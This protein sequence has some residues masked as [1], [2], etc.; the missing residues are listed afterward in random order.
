[1]AYQTDGRVWPLARC[2]LNVAGPG[3][4]TAWKP[5]AVA[6]MSAWNGAGASFTFSS[7]PTATDHLAAYDLGR[8]NGWLAMT[9]TQPTSAG[10][11]LTSGQI[12]VNLY[13]E[14]NPS[15]PTVAP[16]SPKGA[17]DLESVLIHEFGHLLHLADEITARDVM[18]P[19][20]NPGVIRRTL[21]TDDI[22]GIQYLYPML[23]GLEVAELARESVAVVL[24]KVLACGYAVVSLRPFPEETAPEIVFSV[25]RVQVD[26][27]IRGSAGKMKE[28]DVLTLGGQTPKLSLHVQSE[29]A[30]SPNEDVVLF[31]SHD[32]NSFKM[33]PPFE[34]WSLDCVSRHS[35]PLVF[36]PWSPFYPPFSDQSYS[37]FGGF[38]GKYS[39]YLSGDTQYVWRPGLANKGERGF[40]LAELERQIQS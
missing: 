30:L 18:Q 26:R 32:H 8:W 24:G 34:H 3:W 38:Q 29:A 37:V 36:P 28:I 20:I 5:T 2:E 9:Y 13:Y 4:P 35:G 11:S 23:S 39:V 27:T 12:L 22:A 21:G 6:A 10:A 33:H 7:L 17:Y 16:T 15:H 25:H 40:P 1:M 31:L 19:T 14:W